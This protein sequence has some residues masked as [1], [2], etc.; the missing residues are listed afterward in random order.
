MYYNSKIIIIIC[1]EILK[2]YFFPSWSWQYSEMP[3]SRI[4]EIS[5][6]SYGWFSWVLRRAVSNDAIIGKIAVSR[7]S[8]NFWNLMPLTRYRLSLLSGNGAWSQL[9]IYAHLSLPIQVSKV[10][11]PQCYK[12]KHDYSSS[13][14][15]MW[16]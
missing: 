4:S 12:W 11:I 5:I 13:V 9:C 16:E 6:Y 15:T 7:K 1:I 2:L 10:Q 3:L 8:S 14:N